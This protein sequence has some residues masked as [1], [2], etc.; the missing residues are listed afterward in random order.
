MYG[1]SIILMLSVS[2]Y[3][4]LI[5]IYTNLR[6]LKEMAYYECKVNVRRRDSNGEISS[7]EI[8]SVNLVPGDVMEVPEGTK[9]PCDAIMLEGESVVNEAML[10]GESCPVIK[11]SIPNN[12]EI[13]EDF[14][15]ENKNQ[16][17]HFLF[18]G[19]E[20]VQNRTVGDQPNTCLVVK[21][22]F[23]CE[24]GEMIKSILYPTPERFNFAY[25]SMVYLLSSA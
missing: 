14:N 19:T 4:E 17:K 6:Q 23:M 20:V 2:I 15:I 3:G 11:E 1:I 7:Q 22:G 5:T 21:T 25:E 18:S 8:S 13:T 12:N 10:T 16:V 24:K 9:L